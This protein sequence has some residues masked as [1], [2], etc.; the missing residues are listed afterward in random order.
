MAFTQISTTQV[1]FLEDYLRGTG[2]TLSE[3][4]ARAL[5]GIQNLR[6]RISDL[7]D[8][9]LKVRREKNTE[10]RARYAVSARDVTGSRAKIFA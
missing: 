3:A 4:Q 9:G 7:R 5:Y 1:E 10:G 8:A 6:A 2:R